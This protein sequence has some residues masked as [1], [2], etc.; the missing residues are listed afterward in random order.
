MKRVS[1]LAAGALLLLLRAEVSAQEVDWRWEQC[2]P[3]PVW[4]AVNMCSDPRLA[5]A[6]YDALARES[7]P[8]RRVAVRPPP[9]PPIFETRS[10]SGRTYCY[11]QEV[12]EPNA[13]PIVYSCVWYRPADE[14][15]ER[16]PREPG[17]VTTFTA[18]VPRHYREP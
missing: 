6:L 10:R 1:I 9:W 4:N 17:R 14:Q 3:D 7:S 15:V 16:Q 11:R 2:F 8:P 18:P 5:R 13:D 12:Y